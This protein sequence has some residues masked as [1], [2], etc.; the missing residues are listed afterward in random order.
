MAIIFASMA[1][2]IGTGQYAFGVF[3]EPLEQQFAWS[4]TQINASLSF[5]AI[6]SLS[7][8]LVG[9]I[10]DKVGARPVMAASLIL[11]GGSYLLRPFMSELWHWYALSIMQ[12]A[13]MPG[14]AM[15]PAGKLIGTWFPRTRGRML[16]IAMMGANFGGVVMPV[17]ASVL[18]I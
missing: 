12:F 3:V 14:S 8:P 2:A 1:V 6:G 9:R 5:F 4:R 16:G 18:V 13:G 17:F 15:L 11:F 7:A 10:M